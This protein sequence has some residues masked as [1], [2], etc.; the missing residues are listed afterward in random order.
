VLAQ[1]ISNTTIRNCEVAYFQTG[2]SVGIYLHAHPAIPAG[3]TVAQVLKA[4]ET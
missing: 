1:N 3:H 2:I 4:L